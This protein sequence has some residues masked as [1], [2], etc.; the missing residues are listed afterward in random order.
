MTTLN[1]LNRI[2][3]TELPVEFI[4]RVDLYDFIVNSSGGHSIINCGSFFF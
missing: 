1:A 2:V 4:D 3:A